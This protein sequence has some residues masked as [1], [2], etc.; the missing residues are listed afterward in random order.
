MSKDFHNVLVSSV[1]DF[2][3]EVDCNDFYHVEDI[4]QLEPIFPRLYK[5]LK[6]DDAKEALF[7]CIEGVDDEVGFLLLSFKEPLGNRKKKVKKE[8]FK[9]I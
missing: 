8:L 5:E 7:S 9:K 3:R 6:K 1:P 2:I 4:K